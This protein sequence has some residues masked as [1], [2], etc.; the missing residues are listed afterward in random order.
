M[1]GPDEFYQAFSNSDIENIGQVRCADF[2]GLPEQNFQSLDSLRTSN[3]RHYI[4]WFNQLTA[5]VATEI[6]R[7]ARKRFRAKTIE[8]FIDVAKECINVGNFNSLM[9]IVA[10]LSLQPIARLKRTVSNA[11]WY[12]QRLVATNRF[13][14]LG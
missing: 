9:A 14:G 3:I 11:C 1:V 13:S 8:F 6:L 2:A 10:G 4:D 12:T 5:L 7:N